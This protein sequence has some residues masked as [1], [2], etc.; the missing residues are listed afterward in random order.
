[1]QCPYPGSLLHAGRPSL[2]PFLL[3]VSIHYTLLVFLSLYFV[4]GPSFLTV[5]AHQALCSAF[6][7]HSVVC[8]IQHLAFSARSWLSTLYLCP[9]SVYL[10]YIPKRTLPR[11]F[12]SN[13]S[14]TEFIITA[15]PFPKSVPPSM[16]LFSETGSTPIHLNAQVR[17]WEAPWPV[18]LPFPQWLIHHQLLAGQQ[19][20]VL[21]RMWY[22]KCHGARKPTFQI[23]SGPGPCTVA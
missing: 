1:M 14:K 9:K 7:P 13:I 21:R 6:H 3:L 18:P 17:T 2:G 20:P 5:G 4:P 16:F 10:L 12:E 11:H 22:L 15:W 23:Y 8:P 19:R